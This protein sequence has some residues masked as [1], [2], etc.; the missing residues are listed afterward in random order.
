MAIATRG[1]SAQLFLTIA[2][3]ACGGETKPQAIDPQSDLG[4]RSADGAAGLSSSGGSV[5]AASGGQ[6]STAGQASTAGRA[7][8]AGQT[9][10]TGQIS[11][12]GK[13]DADE[14]YMF[15]SI[16][17]GPCGTHQDAVLHWRN[18]NVALVGF[19][20]ES[21]RKAMI[22]PFSERLTYAGLSLFSYYEFV[23]DL[24]VTNRDFVSPKNPM[25]NDIKIQPGCREEAE[26]IMDPDT[27]RLLRMCC[28]Q[29]PC[30][31][32]WP[33][34][35]EFPVPT[36]HTV[37]YLGVSSTAMLDDYSLV[38]DKAGNLHPISWEKSPMLPSAVRADQEGFRVLDIVEGGD[39]IDK[40]FLY[41]VNFDGTVRLV[42][43]Y[44]VFPRNV[45]VTRTG[46]KLEKR[47]A[48]LCNGQDLID[49]SGIVVR[50]EI[51][52]RT[53]VVF[54]PA[55]RPAPLLQFTNLFFTGP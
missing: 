37:S 15:A 9:S 36:G 17:S 6:T 8:T 33:D 24:L 18:P 35:S 26:A 27:G 16:G 55:M 50:G 51:G 42:G 11:A 5:P 49:Y 23:V 25:L 43:Q 47:G 53:E 54:T 40:G 13:F 44:P 21:I 28:E 4:G 3:L 39:S 38:M 34:K 52:V 10:T 41:H 19:E 22:N 12:D 20:C 46:C 29:K 30:R 32:L 7:S 2:L 45:T 31:F 1:R 14:V 48:F